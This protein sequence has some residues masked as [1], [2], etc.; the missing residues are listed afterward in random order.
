MRRFLLWSY[1]LLLLLY[2]HAFRQ[3]FAREMLEF[4]EA[5]SARS[6]GWYH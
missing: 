5:N 2:P 3:R 4:A 1:R 6:R